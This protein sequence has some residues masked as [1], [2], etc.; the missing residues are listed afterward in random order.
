[1]V[2]GIPI[3]HGAIVATVAHDSH[4]IVACGTDDQSIFGAINH[5]ISLRGG[6][7]VVKGEQ[8]LA[9]LSLPLAGLMS[10][11]PFEQV[12]ELLNKLEDALMEI[13]F[14]ESWNPFLTL[15]FLALPVI[16]SLKLTDTGL[17]DVEAFRHI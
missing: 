8:V 17:F 4:N 9:S 2:K 14:R 3:E 5:V 12:N 11:E 16:P 1:M 6:I 7:A 15:S 13:G 10:L